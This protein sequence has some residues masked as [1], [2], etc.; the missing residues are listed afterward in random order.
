VCL[1]TFYIGNLRGVG[2]VWQ[3]TARDAACSYA[4]AWL[5]TELS[6][7]SARRFLTRYL[8]PLYRRAGHAVRAILT[9]GSSEFHGPSIMPASPSASSIGAR[10]PGM[11][12]PMALWSGCRERS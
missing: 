2:K 8:L 11:P 7:R 4:V 10:S 3:F 5:T 9:D 12:G 6:A 1:D